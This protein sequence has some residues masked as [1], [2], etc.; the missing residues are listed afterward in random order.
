MTWE[1]LTEKYV[2]YKLQSSFKLRLIK[3]ATK[4]TEYCTNEPSKTAKYGD[5]FLLINTTFKRRHQYCTKFKSTTT[6]ILLKAYFK[7]NHPSSKLLATSKLHTMLATS[8]IHL[9]FAPRA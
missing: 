6:K 4:Q 3:T 9:R 1:T 8:N 2:M 7:E 5:R